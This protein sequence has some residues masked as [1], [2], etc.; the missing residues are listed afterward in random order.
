MEH[1]DSTTAIEPAHAGI[2]VALNDVIGNTHECALNS[3]RWNSK[4]GLMVEWLDTTGWNNAMLV[5]SRQ[6]PPARRFLGAIG[7]DDGAQKSHLT[8]FAGR[9]PWT[10]GSIMQGAALPVS[11]GGGTPDQTGR[12][13]WLTA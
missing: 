10:I 7:L 11:I 12:L 6:C 8:N 9:N 2:D 4:P 5:E 1:V 13:E 3:A